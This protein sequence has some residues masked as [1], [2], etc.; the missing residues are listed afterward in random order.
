MESNNLFSGIPEQ[1]PQELCETLLMRDGLRL[2]RIVS[3]GHT[4]PPNEWYDQSTDEWV[5]LL[6][7]SATL[8]FENGEA[9]QL[10]PGDYLLI[11]A[12]HRHR[13]EATDSQQKSV[14]L[15]LHLEC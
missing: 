3:H 14:W 6:S 1:L 12:H 8:K 7:G 2:V 15:A 9:Q 5:I 11:P 4:T 13:V 10:N